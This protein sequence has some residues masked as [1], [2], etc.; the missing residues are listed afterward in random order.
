MLASRLGYID[1][2]RGWTMILVVYSHIV[3]L[4]LPPPFVK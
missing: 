1:A 2:M 4:I 3:V